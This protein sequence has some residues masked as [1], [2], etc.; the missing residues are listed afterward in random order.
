[1]RYRPGDKIV[2]WDVFPLK[3]E[4]MLLWRCSDSSSWNI[5]TCHLPIL[6][7][8]VSFH[9]IR[10]LQLRSWHR[11]ILAW[12][13]CDMKVLTVI[14]ISFL[15]KYL[16]YTSSLA[17]K[18]WVVH[19]SRVSGWRYTA[20]HVNCCFSLLARVSVIDILHVTMETAMWNWHVDSSVYIYFHSWR[21]F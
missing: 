14:S 16:A 20:K 11:I 19:T 7:D 15:C 3:W 12:L 1:M 18:K 6:T 2:Q 8:R 21:E 4:V 17:D 10:R 9:L 13:R 5:A